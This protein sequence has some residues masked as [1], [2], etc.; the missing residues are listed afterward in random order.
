MDAERPGAHPDAEVGV[1]IHVT[2]TAGRRPP[3]ALLLV[4][5]AA[6]AVALLAGVIQTR[7][8]GGGAA[9]AP[10]AADLAGRERTF[11]RVLRLHERIFDASQDTSLAFREARGQRGTPATNAR[12]LSAVTPL[13]GVAFRLNRHMTAIPR[14]AEIWKRYLVC[15]FYTARA[16]VGPAVDLA[17]P[18][19]ATFAHAW[20]P[21]IDRHRCRTVV[22]PARGP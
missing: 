8:A 11:S 16:G 13:E 14:A 18:E 5:A 22:L 1:E 12:L 21:T 10:R 20:R 17:L 4:G 3:A 9:T 7:D 19:L 15:A 6:L 2:G